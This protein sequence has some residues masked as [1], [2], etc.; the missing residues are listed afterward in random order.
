MWNSRLMAVFSQHTEEIL[1]RYILFLSCSYD[2][3][4]SFLVIFLF[5]LANLKFSYICILL[6]HYNVSGGE[7]LLIRS[8]W[9]ALRFL[10]PRNTGSF[11]FSLYSSGT[12]CVGLSHSSLFITCPFFY[13]TYVDNIFKFSFLILSSAVSSFFLM[14]WG[15][16]CTVLLRHNQHTTC[17][18][19]KCTLW[20]I[21]TYAF[22][23]KTITTKINNPSPPK[24]SLCPFVML[25]SSLSP[26][27]P[28]VNQ[29]LLCFLSL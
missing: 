20:S 5:S 2:C 27:Q 1:I 11:I 7:S 15:V 21:L 23:H 12:L 8:V 14:H 4:C 24:V 13:L 29:P 19:S 9:D 17:T 22:T 3:N 25:F 16:F 28:L 26:P 10:D 18:Y 6:F